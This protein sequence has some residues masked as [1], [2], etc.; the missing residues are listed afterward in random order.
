MKLYLT[1]G[2]CSQAPHIALNEA[3]FSYE[4]VE[5]DIPTRRTEAGEDF[6]LVNS[7]GYVPALVLDDGEVLTENVAIL[8]WIAEQAPWLTPPGPLGRIRM[9]EALAFLTEEVHKPFL[10]AMF[11][12]GDEAKAISKTAIAHRFGYLAGQL[13][14]DYLFGD[15]FSAA[16]ALLYVMVSW[17]QGFGIAPPP[18]LEAYHARVSARPAV[19]ATLKK[20]GL[21]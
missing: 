1:P 9:I 12:P 6:T 3:G 8:T 20:E 7:K 10:G 5:V 2:A 15:E 14:G 13:R 17:G 18:A 16:D 4:I 21:A 19:Q 11:L